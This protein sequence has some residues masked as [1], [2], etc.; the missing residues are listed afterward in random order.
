MKSHLEL[1]QSPSSIVSRGDFCPSWIAKK[2]PRINWA[3]S[4][5][6]LRELS[7]Q[8]LGYHENHHRFACERRRRPLYVHQPV[9]KN[10]IYA[11]LQSQ[12]SDLKICVFMSVLW[13]PRVLVAK[14]TTLM[15]KLPPSQFHPYPIF[16]VIWIPI[17]WCLNHVKPFV[18]ISHQVQQSN[19]VKLSIDSH[20]HIPNTFWYII[21]CTICLSYHSRNHSHRAS[22]QS[23]S[24]LII[25]FQNHIMNPAKRENIIEYPIIR[26]W[27]IISTY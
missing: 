20:C 21:K 10:D 19:I 22:R 4:S 12:S 9:E 25:K 24:Y 3:P 18:S 23:I 15:L 5:E 16:N 13:T 27:N 11:T 14:K 26:S 1:L 17:L 7:T 8:L 6:H 2:T